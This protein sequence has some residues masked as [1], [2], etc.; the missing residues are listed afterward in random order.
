MLN[1]YEP[2]MMQCEY[3]EDGEWVSATEAEAELAR[4]KALLIEAG[5]MLRAV[6]WGS[7]NRMPYGDQCLRCY[8]HKCEGHNDNCGMYALLARIDAVK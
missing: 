7:Y 1:R 3:Q 6:E 5:Q 4:L 8:G 2:I